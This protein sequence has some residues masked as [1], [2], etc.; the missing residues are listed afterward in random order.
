MVNYFTW[1]SEQPSLFFHY[2][3]QIAIAYNDA[4]VRGRLTSPRG[5]IMQPT[6][7]ESLG[8]RV[9]E[10]L[11]FSHELK[12]NLVGYLGGK[13]LHEQGD[14]TGAIILSWYLQWFGIPPPHLV[15]SALVRV[16]PETMK[17]SAVPLLSMLLPRTR[18]SALS[19]IHK[20]LSS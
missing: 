2:F 8:R 9:E 1:L 5:A 13:W 6:F 4:I 12:V 10:M 17:S 3:L 20:L 14:K 7:I 19:E 11:N 15:K 18:A 16:K